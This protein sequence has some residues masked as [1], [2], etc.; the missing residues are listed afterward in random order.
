[1]NPDW[2]VSRAI[3][4]LSHSILTVSVAV[5]LCVGCVSTPTTQS[6]AAH[7]MLSS[8][9]CAPRMWISAI[10]LVKLTTIGVRIRQCP[11]YVSEARKISI[12]THNRCIVL[13]RDRGE[14]CIRR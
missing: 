8:R 12:E 5:G 11:A 13:D 14:M 4:D 7:V 6:G 1:M 3:C 9:S 10:H 2:Q